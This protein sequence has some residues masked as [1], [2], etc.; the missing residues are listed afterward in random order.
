MVTDLSVAVAPIPISSGRW[1]LASLRQISHNRADALME[2]I[3]WTPY[4]NGK[5][6]AYSHAARIY[7]AVYVIG[8]PTELKM[9]DS[10][11]YGML[12]RRR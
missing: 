7:V 8:K 10:V 11:K 3:F 6:V 12:P 2:T 1:G 5:G 9:P 4:P